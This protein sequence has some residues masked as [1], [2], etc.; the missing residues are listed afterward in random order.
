MA[1]DLQDVEM[2]KDALLKKHPELKDLHVV[3]LSDSGLSYKELSNFI[4]KCWTYDYEDKPR[5]VFSPDLLEF[6]IPEIKS[7]RVSTIARNGSDLVGLVLGIRTN[8]V[9][10]FH[11]E[12]KVF[13]QPNYEY[14]SLLTLSSPSNPC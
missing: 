13:R 14:D 3:P 4:E 2:Q 7:D 12:I 10:S 11:P 8:F 9:F 5:I 1:V 6:T